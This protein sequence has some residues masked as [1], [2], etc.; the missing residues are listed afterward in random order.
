MTTSYWAIDR[1]NGGEGPKRLPFH[2][3]EEKCIKI[4]LFFC[5][6][7]VACYKMSVPLMVVT[8]HLE[9]SASFRHRHICFP[10]F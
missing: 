4:F 1:K 8:Y 6:V 10:L 2:S 9:L 5:D 3:F 7:L